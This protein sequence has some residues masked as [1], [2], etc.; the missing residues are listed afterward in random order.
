MSTAHAELQELVPRFEGFLVE[1]TLHAK[2][3]CNEAV[4]TVEDL[5]TDGVVDDITV[6]TL[7]SV[8][9]GIRASATDIIERGRRQFRHL[10][11]PF[12]RSD[13]KET[14]ETCRHVEECL[15][16][17]ESQI[18]QM[19]QEVAG[20]YQAGGLTRTKAAWDAAVTDW[21]I[22]AASF[23][24]AQCSA[25]VR[26]PELYWRPVDLQCNEC[27]GYTTFLP[28]DNM[29][30]APQTAEKL[31]ESTARNA[32]DVVQ[33]LMADPAVAPGTECAHYVNY[34]LTRHRKLVDLLPAHAADL[35][36]GMAE[37]FRQWIE[38]RDLDL[39]AVGQAHADSAYVATLRG[40][41]DLVDESRRVG[42]DEDAAIAIEI[43]YVVARPGCDIVSAI[44]LG[45]ATPEFFDERHRRI[46]LS[47]KSAY[48][49]ETHIGAAE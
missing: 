29:A 49:G 32:L 21:H 42:A 36:Q 10:F 20:S 46:P 47:S 23:R 41:A 13:D 5:A 3:K 30:R 4:A 11:E 35:R 28:S 31:A 24:C 27:G 39:G 34:L 18:A 43:A 19:A 40:I 8:Q 2:R 15:V 14:K 17:W 45:T 38:D 16:A 9:A 22:A 25:P 7:E 1:L 37:E 12:V 6:R 26:V 48:R 44:V 33:M